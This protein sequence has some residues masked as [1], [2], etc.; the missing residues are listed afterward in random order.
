MA[1][2]VD[3]II[4]VAHFTA[5]PGKEAALLELLCSLMEPTRKE[6]GCLRYEL[7]QE[8]ENPAAFTFAEKFSS[9]EAFESHVKSPY[10]KGFGERSPDLIESRQVRLHRELLPAAQQESRRAETAGAEVIVIAHFTA[11]PGKEEELSTFLQGLV[12]PTRREPGCVRYELN[13]D[14]KDPATFSF[15]ETF[16]DR[17]GFEAHCKMPYIDKLFET[18]PVLVGQQ[19]I[20]LHKRVQV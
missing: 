9:R 18:L 20:G 13:Q 2:H 12:E 6:A 14:L 1:N 10:I 8:I 3:Q 16:A 11:K 7:N 5:K 19:Y 4:V 15:V 17:Q